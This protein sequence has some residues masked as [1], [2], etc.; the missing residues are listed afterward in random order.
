MF[1]TRWLVQV[2]V[3]PSLTLNTPNF[4][5]T[6]TYLF[7]NNILIKRQA[8]YIGRNMR[9]VHST[10]AVIEKQKVLHIMSACL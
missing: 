10:I 7:L 5:H 4:V 1:K 9:R 6:V 3:P 2:H 8:V